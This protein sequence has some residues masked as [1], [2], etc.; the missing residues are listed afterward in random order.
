M[1][2]DPNYVP[3]P[4]KAPISDD[5]HMADLA[6]PMKVRRASRDD[7]ATPSWHRLR[8]PRTYAPRSCL[9]G[10]SAHADPSSQ[11]GDRCQVNPGGKRGCVQFV[12]KIPQIAPGWL[13]GVQYD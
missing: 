5:E 12:G 13:V 6:A 1:K 9:P 11:V 8:P 7:A 2:L 3:E 10:P 4:P